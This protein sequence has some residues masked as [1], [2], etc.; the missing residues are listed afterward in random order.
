[1]TK[2]GNTIEAMVVSAIEY[3]KICRKYDFHNLVFSM[4]SSSPFITIEA[5]R[6]YVLEMQKLNWDY[7]LH[8]GVTEAGDFEDGVIKSSIGIGSLLAD[9]IGDTIRFSLTED[10]TKEIEPA[11]KLI[12]LTKSYQRSSP[13]NFYEK[14]SSSNN[15]ILLAI[16]TDKNFNLDKKASMADIFYLENDDET[17]IAKLK[18]QNKI[19]ISKLPLK[20][21]LRIY[22]LK[23]IPNNLTEKYVLEIFNKDE[24]K[25]LKNFTCDYIIFKPKKPHFDEIYEFLNAYHQ[26]N[27]KASIILHLQYENLLSDLKILAS[28]Q[29]GLLCYEKQFKAI[30]LDSKYDDLD[31]SLN[32]LQACNLKRYKTEFIACPGCGRTLFNLQKTLKQIKDKTSHLKDVK[33]AVMGCIVNGPGEMQDADFGY[34]GSKENSVD[35]YV[36]KKCVEKNIDEKDAVDKLIALIKKNNKW[37]EKSN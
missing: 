27:V 29:I 21:V 16:K 20:D 8:L 19:L 13:K 12:Q 6:A 30:L 31:L 35:L 22:S 2:Y 34:V 5:Y 4:K 15:K 24:L 10:P 25:E 28:F 26:N 7:P 1:M 32:I 3:T 9:G 33:I 23:N 14:N 11:K 37:I 18:K 36:N 17:L